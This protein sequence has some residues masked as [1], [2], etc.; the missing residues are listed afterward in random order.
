MG[1]SF[2]SKV[3]A[4][5]AHALA[6]SLTSSAS[7]VAYQR[8][9]ASATVDPLLDTDQCEIDAGLMKDIGVNTIRVYIVGPTGNHDGCMNT[10]ASQGIYVWI[11]LQS[12]MASIDRTNPAY[13][14]D[15]FNTY[16]AVVDTFSKYENVLSF[17][18]ANE[19]INATQ[20]TDTAPYIKAIVRDVRAYRDKR[21]YRKIPIS[22]TA[23]DTP[24]L[25]LPTISYL[26]CGEQDDTIEMFGMNVFSWCGIS[27]LGYNIRLGHALIIPN[28]I[29]E[30]VLPA[31]RLCQRLHSIPAYQYTCFVFRSGLQC[32][33]TPYLRRGSCHLRIGVSGD[34][35]GS[36]C[37]RMA[38]RREPV[39]LGEIFQLG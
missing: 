4:M 21:G 2:S 12:P 36:C 24:D 22:Y 39:W 17:N 20:Y 29:R 6:P 19:V 10:F 30:L 38:G 13:T 7:G 32:C 8:G 16:A 5:H 9:G 34:L 27:Y 33:R 18:A 28:A 25:Q 14:I 1:L 35:F 23:A 37:L 31:V 15:L 26:T 11:D 3:C